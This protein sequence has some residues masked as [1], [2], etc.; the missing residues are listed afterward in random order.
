[1]H[2]QKELFRVYYDAYLARILPHAKD[3]VV[4]HPVAAELLVKF[5][6]DVPSARAYLGT[7]NLFGPPGNKNHVCYAVG[8]HRSFYDEIMGWAKRSTN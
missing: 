1:M 2:I 5:C 6:E 8:P 4:N 3:G 7:F